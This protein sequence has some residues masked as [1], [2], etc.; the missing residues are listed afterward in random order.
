MTKIFP[1]AQGIIGYQVDNTDHRADARV[2]DNFV[3]LWLPIDL[4]HLSAMSLFVLGEWRMERF[5]Q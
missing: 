1:R 2:I 3:T 4:V 5:S